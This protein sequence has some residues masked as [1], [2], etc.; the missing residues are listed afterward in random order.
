MTEKDAGSDPLIATSA[1]M[2]PFI[3]ALTN[4]AAEK[5]AATFANSA[6]A[7]APLAIA[8]TAQAHFEQTWTLIQTIHPAELDCAAGCCH[9]CY[10]TA[11]TTAAEALGIAKYLRDTRTPEQMR[12]IEKRVNRTAEQVCGLSPEARVQAK[13]P[14]ALLENGK[15]GAYPA[16]PLGCRAWNSRSAG[17]CAALLENS[18]NGGGD[19]RRFQDQR[20]LGIHAGIGAGLAQAL[21]SAGLTEPAERP[22]ELNAALGIALSKPN[23]AERWQAGEDVFA[24]ARSAGTQA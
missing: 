15:C 22:C 6:Q 12:E 23:V 8:K 19:L 7:D 16:R 18:E 10:L 17:V 20:P 3:H 1:K 21:T 11:E 4:E 14:C 13:I 9:C 2:L 24:P 5:C